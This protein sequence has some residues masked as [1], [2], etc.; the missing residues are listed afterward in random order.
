MTSFSSSV[1]TL[2]G[3]DGDVFQRERE[4][5]GRRGLN[6]KTS[7]RLQHHMPQRL[8]YTF[9]QSKTLPRF[10]R[11][12]SPMLYP[13]VTFDTSAHVTSESGV[14]THRWVT[15]LHLPA[16][17]FCF[18]VNMGHHHAGLPNR[19]S[20]GNSELGQKRCVQGHRSAEWVEQALVCFHQ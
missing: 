11:I 16:F 14:L 9:T 2:D 3:R 10:I 8:S 15:M 17:S 7:Y 18:P 19:K 1:A 6:V 13:W 4:I 20:M 12:Y 5:E